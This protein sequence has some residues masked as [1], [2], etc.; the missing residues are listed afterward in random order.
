MARMLEVDTKALT[1]PNIDSY[2]GLIHTFFAL[3]DMYGLTIEDNDGKI[4]FS[5]DSR[6]NK[7][8]LNA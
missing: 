8:S 6:N 1:E 4:C 7:T 3:E 5:F 2:F